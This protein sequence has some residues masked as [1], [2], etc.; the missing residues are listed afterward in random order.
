MT[1]DDVTS[2]ATKLKENW[3]KLAPHLALKSKDIK[4][5]SEDSD[6]VEQQVRDRTCPHKITK[7]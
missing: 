3:K 5:I 7:N 2:Y 6:D 1:T 4:E